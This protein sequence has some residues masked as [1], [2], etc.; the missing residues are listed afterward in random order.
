MHW[1]T[2]VWCLTYAANERASL[3]CTDQSEACVM[4]DQVPPSGQFLCLPHLLAAKSPLP[5]WGSVEL[6]CDASMVSN[7]SR[8]FGYEIKDSWMVRL[9]NS[10]YRHLLL[11][12]FSPF[13]GHELKI[14][15]KMFL[16]RVF[17]NLFLFF[18]TTHCYSPRGTCQAGI[19]NRT[20][21]TC[22][23]PRRGSAARRMR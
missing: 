8:C 4:S 18:C 5:I 9:N 17:E 2:L 14:N 19:E 6:I 12:L 3:P 16:L 10:I 15:Q 7:K 23:V 20:G 1:I 13:F 21:Y 22:A 11:W